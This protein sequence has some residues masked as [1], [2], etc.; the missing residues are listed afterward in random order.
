M[1][2]HHATRDRPLAHG[3]T[4]AIVFWKP[5]NCAPMARTNYGP[6][7]DGTPTSPTSRQILAA[8]L[9]GALAA[10]AD[11]D[12]I[13]DTVRWYV[14]AARE[15]GRPVERVIVDLKEQLHAI[16]A[17]HLYARPNERVL[18][19]SVIRWCIEQYYGANG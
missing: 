13:R 2:L 12:E 16:G 11:P 15:C 18:A 3:T 8:A 19:E 14:D 4:L 17:I 5:T 6:A 1:T 9:R 10:G 7:S